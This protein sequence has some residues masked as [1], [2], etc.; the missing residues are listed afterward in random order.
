[1]KGSTSLNSI[2]LRLR[3]F[4]ESLFWLKTLATGLP[5]T[6]AED[7]HNGHGT[8]FLSITFDE[9]GDTLVAVTGAEPLRFRIPEAAEG[10]SPRTRAALLVLAEAI[11]LDN[12]EN[13]QRIAV[14]PQQE[15]APISLEDYRT[16]WRRR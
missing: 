2:E 14:I 16:G 9:H 4:L 6:R 7:S 1:M 10:T 8:R 11:R 15:P 5:Y 3:A 13:A 12:E